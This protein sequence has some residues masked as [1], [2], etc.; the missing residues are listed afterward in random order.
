MGCS[1]FIEDI[2]KPIE[3]IITCYTCSRPINPD[4]PKEGHEDCAYFGVMKVD[5]EITNTIER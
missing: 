1:H 2:N 5:I 4:D 3:L